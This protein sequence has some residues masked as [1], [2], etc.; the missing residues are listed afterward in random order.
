[1][2]IKKVSTRIILQVS[3]IL[4]L[5]CTLLS[6]S[7]CYL[8]EKSMGNL[9]HQ[10]MLSKVDDVGNVLSDYIKDKLQI[11]NN[12]SDLP[13]IQSMNWDTQKPVLI[14]QAKKWG[15]KKFDV[16]GMDGIV[17]TTS[18]DSVLNVS[19]IEYGKDV[20]KGKNGI[21]NPTKSKIDNLE[22]FDVYVAIKDNNNKIIG[23]LVATIDGGK[24]NS[25]IQTIKLPE[26]G[27]ACV[28]NK[29]G[30]TII[31]RNLDL[32]YTKEN[33]IKNSEKDPSFKELANIHKKMILGETGVGTYKYKGVDKVIAYAP[34]RDT[35]CFLAVAVNNSILFKDLN[36]LKINEIALSAILVLLGIFTS[37]IISKSI[38]NPLIKIKD[39][40]E[41]LAEYDFSTS[42]KVNREDEFGQTVVALNAA[43]DNVRELIKSIKNGA[44]EVSSSSEKLSVT[45]KDMTKN[46]E[47]ITADTKEINSGFQEATATAEE[48]SASVDEVNLSMNAL[49]Q[50]ANDGSNEA[51]KFKERANSVQEKY[52]MT[53][54]ANKKVYLDKEEGILKSI[55][56]GKVVQDIKLMAE[57]IHGIAEQ[58]NLL[59]L[60]AAIEAARAGEMGKGFAV[61][62]GEVKKLAE[63]SSEAV[64]RVKNT[65]DKVQQAFKNLSVSSKELLKFMDDD[66]NSQL[67]SFAKIGDQYYNDA[68]FVSN[69]SEE[70]AAMTEEIT[71]TI[72]QVNLAVKSMAEISQK[73]LENSNEIQGNVNESSN[74]MKQV[75]TTSQVQEELAQK[76]NNLVQKFKL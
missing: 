49:A 47:N 8:S 50:K 13:Q 26:S 39:L 53:I 42:I 72:G 1:M 24:V 52:K 56:D 40:A 29:E 63:Q 70:L 66:I 35:Q 74:A 14:E 44:G 65:I 57:T 51:M 11:V 5:A 2:K 31:H 23:G 55:E 64:A 22:I 73:S 67:K 61:V 15:F 18:G 68:D 4:L 21:S 38:S 7:S 37:F 46:F 75:A 48:V 10:S 71:Y 28:I 30:T 58:T 17:H 33:V 20:L 43:Q 54:S 32:V 59:A 41:R 62:A 36:Y 69:M 19:D 9:I 3:V 76:L 25:F 27:Y 6:A 34:V 45:V 16:I 60:N 12:I